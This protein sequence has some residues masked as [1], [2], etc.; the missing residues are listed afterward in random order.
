MRKLISRLLTFFIIALSPISFADNSAATNSANL[1][2]AVSFSL[3][4]VAGQQVSLDDYRGKV[5]L[6]DFWASWCT[7]CIRSF[8]WMNKMIDNYSDDDFAV[9]AINMDQDPE[10]AK[11]F[12]QRYPNKMT[13]AFDPN[14]TVAELYEVMGLPNSFILNKEGEIVYKHVGFRLKDVDNYE[15]EIKSLLN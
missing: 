2:K 12:L 9:I 8:P 4:G 1:V 15:A 10:L 14:G 7:P 3:P 5:V 11:K 6:V 13:I